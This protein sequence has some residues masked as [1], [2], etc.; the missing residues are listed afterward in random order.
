M[1]KAQGKQI[2][3]LFSDFDG[4]ISPM[5]VSE[6]NSSVFQEN[7]GVLEEISQKIPTAIITTKDLP[8]IVKRT[9][10]AHAWAGIGGLETK[11]RSASCRRLNVEKVAVHMDNALSFATALEGDGV[12]IEKKRFSN[13]DVVAFSVDWRFAGKKRAALKRV[14]RI[15]NY[16]KNLP[17]VTVKYKGQPF[18]DVFPCYVDK[19]KALVILKEELGQPN[20]ILYMG[21]SVMDNSAFKKADVAMG[22]L[23]EENSPR[24]H[25]DFYVK[26]EN[27]PHFLRDLMQKNFIF[28]S[29]SA[30]INQPNS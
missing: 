11:S 12:E 26:F 18:F 3:A 15:F 8:F 2:K 16:C 20:G 28:N 4:T 19:G 30:D 22:V 9:P 21:D 24:L 29:N 17:L 25:C 7:M 6:S 10:F 27:V 23:H 14:F 1:K 5:D 13:G